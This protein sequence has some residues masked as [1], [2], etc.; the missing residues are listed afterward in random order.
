MA[1]KKKEKNKGNQMLMIF[2]MLTALVFLPTTALLF[3]GMLPTIVA[4]MVDRTKKKTKAVTVGAMNIAG[5]TPF[6]LELWTKGNSFEQSF[7]I[8]SKPAVVVTIYSAACIGYMIDWAMSGIVSNVLYQKGLARQQAIIDRQ[9]DLIERWGKEVT[10]EIPLDAQGF[11]IETY[12]K[13]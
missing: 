9:E 13:E 11:P 4:A 2:G 8:M 7:A 1:R 12:R 10:G 5:C 6:L 3:V